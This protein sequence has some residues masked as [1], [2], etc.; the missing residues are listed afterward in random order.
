MLVGYAR[1]STVDQDPEYQLR[2]LR[3]HGCEKIFTDHCT[4]RKA[5]RPQLLAAL[6]FLRAADTLAVWKFDRL[7][8]DL[9]HLIE[10]GVQLDQ[11]GCQLVS[12][13][14]AIDTSTPGGKLIFTVFAAMAQFESDLNSERT[15]E[16]YRVKQA[17]G[18]RWG[19][20]SQFHD[21]ETV[22][23]AKALLADR[24]LSRSEIA[25]RFGVARNVIYAWFPGGDPDAYDGTDHRQ[26]GRQP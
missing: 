25:R 14:E 13:T 11:R 26:R 2:A 3:E 7:A 16:A 18:V 8:R 5:T 4:G 12:L 17:A 10:L 15:R 23:L 1:V 21:P 20:R 19:R 22:R 6:E 24:T 9:R